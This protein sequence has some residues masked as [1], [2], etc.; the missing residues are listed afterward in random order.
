MS[1]L[2]VLRAARD[3]LSDK[4]RWTSGAYARDDRGDSVSCHSRDARRWCV[5]GAVMRSSGYQSCAPALTALSEFSPWRAKG[6]KPLS[7]AG[8]ND[9][10]FLGYDAVIIMLGAAI[11]ALEDEECLEEGVRICRAINTESDYPEKSV[12]VT[13]AV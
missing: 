1:A 5:V 2:S 4:S 7:V 3:L 6:G 11:A 8:V 10:T 13:G 12:E 9:S